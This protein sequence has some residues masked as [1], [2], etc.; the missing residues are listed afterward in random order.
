MSLRIDLNCD[1]GESF[2]PW[3]MGRDEEVMGAV[4]SINVACGFH[5][6]DPAVM[7]RT[8][9]SAASH[10]VA[11]GAHPGLPD[12]QGFGRRSMAITPD[13]ARAM[14]LYQ[15]GAQHA[16]TR[17]EGIALTHVKPHGALYNMAAGD[18]ALARAIALAVRDF[19]PKLILVGL[20]GSHL[21]RE[22][23][24]AGLRAAWEVFA[25]RSYDSDGK[26]TPRSL[27]GAMVE[28]E[29]LAAARVLRM[30]KEGLVL[31]RQGTDIALRA[32]TVCIHGDQPRAAAFALR[33]RAALREAGVEVRAL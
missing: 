4:T 28:D 6:G 1:M 27:P 10:G 26:L 18:A 13:E 31:S 17:A 3:A 32:D 33:V 16:F 24:A 29:D 12:L 23:E 9:R 2:G 5:A 25:D 8:V 14:V 30:V 19:D 11:V 22:A 7:R 20:A 21:V 15:V